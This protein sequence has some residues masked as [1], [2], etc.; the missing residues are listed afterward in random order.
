MTRTDE[1]PALLVRVSELEKALD[2]AGR[3]DDKDG[4]DK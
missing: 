2:R 4:N 1:T 3:S